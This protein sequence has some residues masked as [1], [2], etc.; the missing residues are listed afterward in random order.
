MYISSYIIKTSMRLRIRQDTGLK[1]IV[2]PKKM[3]V[4]KKLALI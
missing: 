3:N 2:I 4:K 1:L